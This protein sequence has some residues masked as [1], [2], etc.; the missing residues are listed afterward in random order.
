V[1]VHVVTQKGHGYKPAENAPDK[2]HGVQKFD[3]ITGVQV[4]SQSNAPKYQAVFASELVKHAER[5]D[6]IV[7]ITAAMPS[8]TSLDVFAKRFR[9]APSMSASPS[10]TR[11]PSPP[12]SPPTA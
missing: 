7:A 9:A 6:K 3:V 12:A 8:G 2:Y 4:K 1:L 11:S 10:S 5:D